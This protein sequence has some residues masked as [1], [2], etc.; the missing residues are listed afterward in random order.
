MEKARLV[1]ESCE[2][3]GFLLD[4]G[5][6]TGKATQ[7]FREKA[8]CIALDPAIE[9][10]KQFPGIKVVARAE[11][12]PFKDSSFDSIISLTALHH[13]D[14]EKANAEMERVAK[15]N[16]AIAVSFFKRAGNFEQA[17]ALF[18]GFKEIDSEKDLVFVRD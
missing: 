12:L 3:H 1:K 15:G 8:E 7:M 4:I 13:A 17:K 11:E 18:K 16:A 2:L 6:G 10:V 14:L 5:A 9:M